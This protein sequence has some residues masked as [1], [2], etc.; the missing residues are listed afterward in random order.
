MDKKTDFFEEENNEEKSLTLGFVSDDISSKNEKSEEPE[1]YYHDI[2][3][4]EKEDRYYEIF[5]K[6][7][8]KTRAWSVAAFVCGILSLLL[9]YFGLVGIF[10]AI[11]AV[12][13]AI[14]SRAWLGY[15]DKMSIYGLILGIFGGVFGV[16][17]IILKNLITA[18]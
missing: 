3:A 12:S 17:I 1:S 8:H 16:A 14:V 6:S 13:L 11:A 5:E 4:P 10:V 18:I 9:S 15:F 7:K 2:S